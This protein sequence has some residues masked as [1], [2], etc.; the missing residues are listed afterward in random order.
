MNATKFK[1]NDIRSVYTTVAKR[2]EACLKEETNQEDKFPACSRCK[3]VNYCCKECQVSHWKTH[4]RLCKK[5]K[6]LT[7]KEKVEDFKNQFRPLLMSLTLHVM[8][9]CFGN[10]CGRSHWRGHSHLLMVKLKKT[11]PNSPAGVQI[12][13]TDVDIIS[14]REA[15]LQESIREEELLA[16]RNNT[17]YD[18]NGYLLLIYQDGPHTKC[19]LMP[20]TFE[21]VF[22]PESVN[23]NIASV[24]ESH[25]FMM[26]DILASDFVK[27]INL[28]ATGKATTSLAAAD[29]GRLL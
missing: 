28:M 6:E 3:L 12:E 17:R 19:E 26:L 18:G 2:C 14:N 10:D 23:Q 1:D 5:K 9:R 16:A 15:F 22:R 11:P 27:Q 13:E 25:Q 21:G 8:H 20:F 4:K 7:L 24:P 29:E